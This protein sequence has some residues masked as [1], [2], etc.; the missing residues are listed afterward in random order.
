MVGIKQGFVIV[1]MAVSMTLAAQSAR[2]QNTQRPAPPSYSTDIAEEE[3]FHRLEELDRKRKNFAK[4]IPAQEWQTALLGWGDDPPRPQYLASLFRQYDDK[5]TTRKAKQQTI[6]WVEILADELVQRGDAHMFLLL[7]SHYVA[8]DTRVTFY[9]PFRGANTTF[10]LGI[11][12]LGKLLQKSQASLSKDERDAFQKDLGAAI[13]AQLVVTTTDEHGET[14]STPANGF[15]TAILGYELL[16]AYAYSDEAL[17][18]LDN[19]LK[20]AK[21]T[22][23]DMQGFLTMDGIRDFQVVVS[24]FLSI[25]REKSPVSHLLKLGLRVDKDVGEALRDLFIDAIKVDDPQTAMIVMDHTYELAAQQ[26]FAGMSDT[27]AQ[28][29]LSPIWDEAVASIMTPK[30]MQGIYLKQYMTP[31]RR[32]PRTF[33]VARSKRLTP[34]QATEMQGVYTEL[35]KA[36]VKKPEAFYK[37]VD[38]FS[39]DAVFA[40]A[41][42]QTNTELLKQN[43]MPHITH[44]T[45]VY[46]ADTS[47]TSNMNSNLRIS[48]LIK[49][50]AEL[51]P[52]KRVTTT[53]FQRDMFLLAR[54][55]KGYPERAQR[56]ANILASANA[57]GWDRHITKSFI[58]AVRKEIAAPEGSAANETLDVILRVQADMRARER[59]WQARTQVKPNTK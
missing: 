26:R 41:L 10:G 51:Q 59:A 34:A 1:G 21:F 22:S 36:T 16:T 33:T 5:K 38:D 11:S 24:P 27:L 43:I 54:A 42:A 32:I 50:D 29:M 53:T 4:V 3:V 17:S 40:A 56:L 37:L 55:C 8:Y 47:F 12:R 39:G 14:Q 31:G 35:L 30:I 49:L 9:S 58:D 46:M 2:A 15:I 45:A 19:E 44:L 6:Q 48:Q 23:K 52:T 20:K 28:R 13:A 25:A 57:S 7:A 18:V